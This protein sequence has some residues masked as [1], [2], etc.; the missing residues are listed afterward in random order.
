MYLEQ[1]FFVSA[2]TGAPTAPPTSVCTTH[3]QRNSLQ[4]KRVREHRRDERREEEG[5]APSLIAPSESERAE[6]TYCGPNFCLHRK[7]EIDTDNGR[8]TESY[9][10]CA[11][12]VAYNYYGLYGTGHK[13][14][15]KSLGHSSLSISAI[16]CVAL[17]KEIP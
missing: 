15:Y 13:G 11:Y 5:S 9:R 3:C 16:L 8:G 12:V 17:I 1:D 10:V 6:V 4:A 2:A 14:R 7:C